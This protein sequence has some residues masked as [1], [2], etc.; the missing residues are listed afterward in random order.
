M[1]RLSSAGS[2]A[3]LEARDLCTQFK[4]KQK[5]WV[6]LQELKLS[7][8]NGIYWEIL[9]IIEHITLLDTIREIYGGRPGG[10][11]YIAHIIDIFPGRT[12][13]YLPGK[14]LGLIQQ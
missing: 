3:V 9:C 11:R 4:M 1:R 8:N 13:D 7:I 12:K 6:G 14:I 5:G 10:D 2:D